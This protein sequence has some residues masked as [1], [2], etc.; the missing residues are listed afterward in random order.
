[1]KLRERVLV[2]TNIIIQKRDRLFDFL[3]NYDPIFSDLIITEVMK[4]I[5]ENVLE[6]KKKN[7]LEVAN[8]YLAF[9]QKFLKILYQQN[10]QLAYPDMRDF[11]D[12]FTLMLERDVDAVDAV[13]AVIA[14]RQGVN[15]LS[16]DK[17]LD[18]LKDY[19]K[20]ISI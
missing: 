15:V 12:A 3:K 1:M 11:V 16:N 7:R 18:R 14:K 20:R 2:D 6:S 10:T 4:V 8:K 19:T 5:R 9:G 13:I 17:D